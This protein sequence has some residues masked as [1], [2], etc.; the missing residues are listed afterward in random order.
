MPLL[1]YGSAEQVNL[2]CSHLNRK[3]QFSLFSFHFVLSF[4][5]TKCQLKIVWYVSFVSLNG[6]SASVLAHF[7]VWHSVCSARNRNSEKIGVT[8]R[9]EKIINNIK[10]KNYEQDYWY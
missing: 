10:F 8:Q 2:L 6:I 4:V 7:F 1:C 9:V 5:L 3:V